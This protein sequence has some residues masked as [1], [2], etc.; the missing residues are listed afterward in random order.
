MDR[1]SEYAGA[2]SDLTMRENVLPEYTHRELLTCTSIC[3]HGL[4]TPDF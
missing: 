3:A 1:Y 4:V 2:A